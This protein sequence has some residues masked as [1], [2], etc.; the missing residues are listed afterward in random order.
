MLPFRGSAQYTFYFLLM[1]MM[2]MMIDKPF[3]VTKNLIELN[4]QKTGTREDIGIFW[5]TNDPSGLQGLKD[6][7]RGGYSHL[8]DHKRPTRSPRV[9]RP[10]IGDFIAIF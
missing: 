1:M 2:M 3:Y 9:I 7:D 4:P 5:T 10:G 8:W 6:G